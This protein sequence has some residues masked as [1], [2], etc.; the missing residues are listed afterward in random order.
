MNILDII[1][2][3]IL[4]LPLMEM[5]YERKK[6]IQEISHLAIQLA[7]HIVKIVTV[8]NPRDKKHWIGEVNGWLGDVYKIRIKPRSKRLPFA[9]YYQVL[10]DEP[11]GHLDGAKLMMHDHKPDQYTITKDTDTNIQQ[12]YIA[13]CQNLAADICPKIENYLPKIRK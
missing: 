10:W 7:Y 2:D 5:A 4:D 8:N 6:A 11:L 12:I 3:K 1:A 9:V 13:I